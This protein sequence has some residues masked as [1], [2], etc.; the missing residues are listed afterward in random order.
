MERVARVNHD[1]TL[2]DLT[3]RQQQIVWLILSGLHNSQIAA[4][5][6]LSQYTI[7]G[8]RVAMM[9]RL[10]ISNDAQL[11]YWAINQGLVEL[12]PGGQV[13]LKKRKAK[14]K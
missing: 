12:C 7:S 11:A 6:K 1:A 13:V 3:P 9:K 14:T 8:Y 4:K 2:Q 10:G 5:L